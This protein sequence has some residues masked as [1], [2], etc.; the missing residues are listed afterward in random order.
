MKLTSEEE[1]ILDRLVKVLREQFGARE[2]VLYG[3]AARDELDEGSDIDLLIVLPEVNW[4]V[5]KEIIQVCF[6]A[7][8]ECG[9]V[10]SSVCYTVDELECGP[11]RQSPLILNARREGIVL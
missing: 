6:S 9:R 5:E 7:E 1:Q 4:E 10:F 11:L 3:S 2:I 8:L